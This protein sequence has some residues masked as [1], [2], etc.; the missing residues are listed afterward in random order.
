VRLP[1][2]LLCLRDIA[3]LTI[4]LATWRNLNDNGVASGGEQALASAAGRASAS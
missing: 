2:N 4:G 3:E 1:I